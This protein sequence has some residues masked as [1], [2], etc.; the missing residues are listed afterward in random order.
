MKLLIFLFIC[1]YFE[2]YSQQHYDTALYKEVVVNEIKHSEK[3]GNWVAL[4]S[5]QTGEIRFWPALTVNKETRKNQENH[6][7]FLIGK[8]IWNKLS[9]TKQ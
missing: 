2:A 5:T 1:G 9:I 4:Q 3:V 7:C 6:N 8:D